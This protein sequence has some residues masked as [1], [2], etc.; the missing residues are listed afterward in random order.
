MAAL[1]RSNMSMGTVQPNLRHQMAVVLESSHFLDIPV[2]RTVVV[3][4]LLICRKVVHAI[5][6]LNESFK[7][8]IP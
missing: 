1:W 2:D 4:W 8:G 5:F 3:G 7:S 6:C